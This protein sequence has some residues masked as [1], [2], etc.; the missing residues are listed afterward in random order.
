M[1]GQEIIHAR[2]GIS[3]LAERLSTLGARRLLV[4]SSPTRR[5]VDPIVEALHA[6]EPL[7]VT[8]VFDGARVHVPAEVVEAASRAL[9]Q[10]GADTLVA[11]GGGSAIGLGK[12]LRLA[13]P[14]L[15]F[16]VVPTTYAGSEMTS[17]W[18]ITRANEKTTGRDPRVRP[19][20]VLYDPTL[21]AT[22][23]IA[24]TVQSLMNAL[25]HPASTLSTGSLSG[26]DR[27]AAL[28]AAAAVVR[29]IE[30]LLLAPADLTLR[31]EA[32]RAAA[33]AAVALDRGKPGVQHAAA[34]SLGGA[35]GLDHAALHS[36]LLPQFVAHVRERDARLVDELE[37]AIGCGPL[38]AHLHDLL[39]RAGAPTA[40]DALGVDAAAAQ[41]VIDAR[42]DLPAAMIRDA[43]SGL[44]P[45]RARIELGPP[46]LALLSGPPLERARR[47]V[48]ALHGRGAEAGGIV[49]RYSEIAG[50]DPDV[51][52]IG[53]RAASG[54]NRWYGVR[55]GEPGASAD[56]EVTTALARVDAALAALSRTVPRGAT[57]LAGFSQGA[58][59]ALEYAARSGAGLAAVVA[60]C[61][62]RI[63]LPSEWAES[64]ER[65]RDGGLAGLSVLLGAGAKDQWVD[66][67]RIDA[68]AAWFREAGAVVDVLSNPGERHDISPRQRLRARELIRGV[69]ADTGRGGL[70]STL[71]SEAVAGALPRH[72]NSP[73]RPPLGLYAEQ[74]NGTAFTAHRAENLRTWCYRIRPASQRRAFEPL[75]HP[76]FGAA[77]S[78]R[79]PEVNLTGWA[80]LPAPE[81]PTD[82]IDGLVTVAG[83]G[84]PALR[85][86][87][88]VH[89]YSANRD[90]DRRAFY[91]ADGD[92]LLV[93]EQGALTVL[94][95]LGPLEVAPGQIAVLPRGLVFSVLL[96]GPLARGY[97]A[98]A[99]GRHFQL[100]E[101]GPVGANG[102]ADPRHFR[103]PAAWY[104]DKLAPD[105]R[106]VAKL[107]GHLQQ[108]SQDHSPF[109]VVA[110]HGNYFP[111]RYDLADFSPV[112][113]VR[114]DHPDPS[115]YTVLSA[116]LDEPG[117]NSLDFIVFAPRWDVALGTFRPPYFHR[118]PVSEVNG[119]IRETA[120]PGSPFQPGC[121]FLTPSL[122]AH[123]PGWRAVE[124]ARTV[125]PREAD[126]PVPPGNSL[127]FQFETTL[128]LSLT[129]WADDNR[130]AGWSATWGSH[131][132]YFRQDGDPPDAG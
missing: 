66:M 93:P 118:N 128:P 3:R 15:R 121:C 104:E 16:A 79:P 83:A 26:D 90:M 6:V 8:E 2:H 69:R 114:L 81:A 23:P 62:A 42:S 64:A 92:L 95:E 29:A 50:Q 94:T 59:L 84:S 4:L 46:P 67:E 77:F 76:R 54:A 123:G 107:G 25:A 18:G 51:A 105:F 24:V 70:A 20:L 63:G 33:A 41:R 55:Y 110:W 109:D 129:A 10:A 117:A 14:Q 112:G 82:F 130:V 28:A 72:Q 86:G 126:Q 60:P 99:F 53:L 49:R 120:P 43:Q 40:L 45:T 101:R 96:A 12:A 32:L 68:T 71:E 47:A 21:T 85:R 75:P 108:A 111:C 34:H 35:L 103:A 65:A 73:R 88:A 22:L 37:G 98:E 115:I 38:E 27:S 13:Q 36:V 132:S 125:D 78:G 74:I 102:L 48:L 97:V 9:E 5:F 31:E 116:P 131:R 61:G 57:T 122:T 17:M 91:D 7:A 87:C 39:T 113:S 127:W 124:R 1:P 11:V 56:P 80:P 19:D 30:D 52:V 100:P 106:I 44:R 119:I 58:C 89:L